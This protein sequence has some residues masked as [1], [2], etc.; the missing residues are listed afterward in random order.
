[1]STSPETLPGLPARQSRGLAQSLRIAPAHSRLVGGSLIMLGG[2]VLVSLLNFGYNIAVARMLGAAEFSQ[3][4]AAVTLLMIVSCLTL[5]FQMVC[6]K[7]V[8]RNA[9]NSEK[10]HVYRALLRRAWTAGLSIGIVLTIF[11]RQVAAWLN[12]PSATLVIVLALGMAF[13]VPLGVRRG[14]MQG[15]YQF[16]RLSLNFIIETSVK[17]VSAIVLVHLGYGILGAVAAISI[18]V[19]AAYFLPPTPIALRE[20]PKAGL[21]ASFGE[22]IQAIIFFIGQ[23]IINNIDILMVKHFFRPDVAGLY[24]AVALVG[25]VLYIASWQVISAM[26][27][28]AAAGRSESEGRE[29]RMVVLIPFGFVT[30]MTVVFMAILG[31]FPQTILHL[32]FGAK[33]NTDSSNLLLLYAAATGGYALSVVLMAYEMSRRIANTGWF[34]LV[35]SGLV[36]L[37]I[38][39][40]HNTLRDVIV[41]QQVLMVVLFTAVAVPFVLARRFRTRGAA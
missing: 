25:R 12:M 31:L 11:N 9:T 18:S 26:F 2:M 22:G 40:F 33:F 39:M 4:A 1:M 29:S 16:R 6:A 37:G 24:A 23:V 13:Y 7:F 41:V 15:V 14:G 27:P 3:A 38:T 30:A 35:I 28:I 19:V 32:L 21:P 34:Q 5:A 17:L 8:A 10:S 36:V 20:Q